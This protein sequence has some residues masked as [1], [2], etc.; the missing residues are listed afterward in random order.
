MYDIHKYFL[1]EYQKLTELLNIFGQYGPM[2]RC[3]HRLIPL[4]SSQF[5]CEL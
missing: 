1:P 3:V 5:R 2:C 4:D